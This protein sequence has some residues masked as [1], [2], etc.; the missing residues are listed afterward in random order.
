MTKEDPSGLLSKVVRFVTSPTTN[1]GDLN[2]PEEDRDSVYNKQALK[3]MIERKRRNDFVRR[4][5]F[6]Q[7]RKLRKREALN[8]PVDPARPSFFQSSLAS[9]IEDRAGTLKKIDEIEAQMSMQWWRAK[10]G[11]PPPGA[12]PAVSPNAFAP[13]R[14]LGM[15]SAAAPLAAEGSPTPAPIPARKPQVA[16]SDAMPLSMPSSTVSTSMLRN[17]TTQPG[18]LMPS[19]VPAG[20]RWDATQPATHFPAFAP[21]AVQPQGSSGPIDFSATQS[22]VPDSLVFVHLPEL[23]EAAIRYANGDIEAAESALLEL[24]RQPSLARREPLWMAL[25]DLYR[26]TGQQDRFDSAAIDFAGIFGK[27]GPLWG[28]WSEEPGRPKQHSFDVAD[29]GP[30]YQ[31]IAPP[32]LTSEVVQALKLALE[33]AA[34]PWLLDWM[35][36]SRIEPSA[37]D[38]LA[39]L[40]ADWANSRVRLRWQGLAVLDDLLRAQTPSGQADTPQSWWRLRMESLRLL[41]RAEEFE[42]VALDYCVTYELSPPSWQAPYCECLVLSGDGSAMAAQSP[43]VEAMPA[44]ASRYQTEFASTALVGEMSQ[45]DTSMGASSPIS[46]ALSGEV[47]TDIEGTLPVPLPG[48]QIPRVLV[49]DCARLVRIDFLAA[50]SVLNWAAARQAEGTQVQFQY[51]NRLVAVFFNVIGINEHARVIP[52]QD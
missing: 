22:F 26:S 45:L 11:Q 21:T 49:V 47:T 43:V 51:L 15:D 23:E 10:Q 42:L 18:S 24:L 40:V 13:T 44:Q 20:T 50:G 17:L 34:S 5:E 41:G 33:R 14:P 3:E 9:R 1:W 39:D 35:R 31:W 27:S 46:V 48:Y 30:G 29:Q 25:F 38:P 4:R 16:P 28:H 7:L 36:L 37:V 19:T 52:R 8:P 2:Q 32:V 12:T 6:D